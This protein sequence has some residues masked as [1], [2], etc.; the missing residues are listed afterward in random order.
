MTRM[1]GVVQK[2]NRANSCKNPFTFPSKDS[3]RLD[4]QIDTKALPI[5]VTNYS[6][7]EI[8]IGEGRL[9]C[10][11]PTRAN[12]L[13]VNVIKSQDALL[14]ASSLDVVTASTVTYTPAISKRIVITNK[15]P[16]AAQGISV[17]NGALPT[18]TVIDSNDCTGALA[19]IESCSI[20]ITS[21]SGASGA[22][23]AIPEPT[24]VTV[25][26]SNTN[27]ILSDVTV[28]RF[29]SVLSG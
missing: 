25:E 12:L 19:V 10:S 11:I 29:S 15:G 27:T 22:A 14:S 23:Y 2:T 13:G 9:S 28:L 24:L 18:G 4:L 21:G 5:G 20:T 8:W 3:C 26:G 6:G 1:T 16:M 7:P 17:T